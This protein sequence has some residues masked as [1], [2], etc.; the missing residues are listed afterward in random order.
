M[1]SG[2][3]WAIWPLSEWNS[4]E[5]VVWRKNIR[6]LGLSDPDTALK[7]ALKVCTSPDNIRDVMRLTWWD[8]HAILWEQWEWRS[9]GDF[10]SSTMILNDA[11]DSEVFSRYWF[12]E[13]TRPFSQIWSWYRF[14]HSFI[15]PH[16]TNMALSTVHI[17]ARA[18][19]QL[20]FQEWLSEDAFKAFEKSLWALFSYANHDYT[21]HKSWLIAAVTD[22]NINGFIRSNY[23]PENK[24]ESIKWEIL[25]WLF[26]KDIVAE[27]W[28]SWHPIFHSIEK[29]TRLILDVISKISDEK[30]KK[31]YLQVLKYPLFSLIGSELDTPSNINLDTLLHR[32]DVSFKTLTNFF[33]DYFIKWSK[34]FTKN[35]D[36][37]SILDNGE[38]ILWRL[39][40]DYPNI[41]LDYRKWWEDMSHTSI[42][43]CDVDFPVREFRKNL[44]KAFQED[45]LEIFVRYILSKGV[46]RWKLQSTE[47]LYQILQEYY[48]DPSINNTMQKNLEKV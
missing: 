1:S 35:K 48:E 36:S 13:L 25:S 28:E 9:Y 11:C 42:T 44:M 10:S 20:R 26:H 30:L 6:I 4:P 29:N 41:D 45:K 3:L 17:D 43:F 40:K 32:W 23:H 2:N 27:L 18:I 24:S 22:E 19:D 38:S 46:N 12:V 31:Y 15:M 34:N 7:N 47:K 37:S 5:S 14:W 39:K 21:I 16:T 33:Q 8:V